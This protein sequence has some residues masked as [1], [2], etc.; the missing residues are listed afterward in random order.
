MWA[1]RL[2]TDDLNIVYSWLKATLACHRWNENCWPKIWPNQV[3]TEDIYIV[4]LGIIWPNQLL[5]DDLKIVDSW[6][7]ETGFW[8]M[9]SALMTDG[10][11]TP[12]SHRWDKNCSLKIWPNWLLTE[13]LNI[14][15]SSFLQ[16]TSKLFIHDASQPASERGQLFTH[17]WRPHR[18][19]TDEMKIVHPRSHLTRYWQRTCTLFP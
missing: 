6:Y 10:F 1:N 4:P 9:T 5:T 2:L 7:D 8:Q 11:A 16:M 18:L 12:A 19:V 13:D 15:R 3:L 14:V 17:G